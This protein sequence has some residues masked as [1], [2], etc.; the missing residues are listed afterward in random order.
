MRDVNIIYNRVRQKTG[1]L[2][3]G[4]PQLTDMVAKDGALDGAPTP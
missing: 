1:T 3:L 4:R 2:A